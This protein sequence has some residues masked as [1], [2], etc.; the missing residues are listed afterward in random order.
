MHPLKAFFLSGC[1]NK[2]ITSHIQ[3]LTATPLFLIIRRKDQQTEQTR[4][5]G[6]ISGKVTLSSVHLDC[7]RK[8]YFTKLYLTELQWAMNSTAVHF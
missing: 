5:A 3:I 1:D 2:K 8:L 6:D 4:P 7:T